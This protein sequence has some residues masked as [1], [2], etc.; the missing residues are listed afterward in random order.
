MDTYLCYWCQPEM[1]VKIRTDQAKR[2]LPM[3]NFAVQAHNLSFLIHSLLFYQ[4]ATFGELF[5]DNQKNPI[6]TEIFH[7]S[8]IGI[9]PQRYARSRRRCRSLL[10]IP[11]VP[12]SSPQ[13]V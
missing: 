11:K 6:K 7:V 5:S 4:T 9:F 10:Q 1:G 12:T 2:D 3:S 8:Y 13:K